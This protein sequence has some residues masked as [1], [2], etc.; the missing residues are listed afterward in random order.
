MSNSP[1]SNTYQESSSIASLYEE[2]VKL[3]EVAPKEIDSLDEADMKAYI[4]LRQDF[5]H[6]EG[7]GYAASFHMHTYPSQW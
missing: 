5:E 7:Q 1:I 3:H 4:E 6:N 2:L